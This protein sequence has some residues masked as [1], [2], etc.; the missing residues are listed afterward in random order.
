MKLTIELNDT[1]AEEWT[2][3]IEGLLNSV[4]RLDGLIGELTELLEEIKK[5]E[6]V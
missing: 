1:D 2:E 5:K 4:E 6:N 3:K